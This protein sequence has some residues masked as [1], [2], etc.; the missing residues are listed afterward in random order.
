[1]SSEIISRTRGK[2]KQE[3]ERSNWKKELHKKK[4]KKKGNDKRSYGTPVLGALIALSLRV[5]PSHARQYR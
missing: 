2:K 5:I 1:M 3:W 4:R